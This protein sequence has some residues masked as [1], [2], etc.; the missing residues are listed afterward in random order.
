MTVA[1]FLGDSITAGQSNA[2]PTYTGARLGWTVVNLGVGGTGYLN[3]AF[4]GSAKFRDRIS[5]VVAAGPD[6]VVV[7]GGTNDVPALGFSLAALTAE[8]SLFFAAL[9]AALPSALVYALA[10]PAPFTGVRTL[11]DLQANA[12]AIEAAVAGYGT[13]IDCG[14]SHWFT[15]SGDAGTPNGTGNCDIYV[16]AGGHPNA[17]GQ[18]YLGTRLAF[19]IRPPATG[20]VG[21]F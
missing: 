1:A 13:Y 3:T 18:G 15:G 8:L 12:D 14:P 5:T 7:E 9:R 11:S 6:V 2:F 16:A 20:L 21:S 10:P 4:G 19:S 17:A